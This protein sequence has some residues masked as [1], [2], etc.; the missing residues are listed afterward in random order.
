[1]LVRKVTKSKQDRE[2]LRILD[3]ITDADKD[4]Q[5]KIKF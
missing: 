4:V 3:T 5:M 1:M 2:I